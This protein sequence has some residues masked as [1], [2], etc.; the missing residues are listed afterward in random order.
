MS[1]QNF[2]DLIA[3]EGH[4]VTIHTYLDTHGEPINASVECR[5]CF[6][7]LL[8]FDRDEDD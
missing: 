5:E 8:D 7:V 2:N 3:H 6:E 4:E 1:A